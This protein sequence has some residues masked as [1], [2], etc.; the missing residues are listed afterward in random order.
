[1]IPRQFMLATGILL[2]LT[3][4]MSLY[5]WQLRRH[6]LLKPNPPQAAQHVTVPT[7]GP[8][9]KVTVYVAYDNPGELHAQS[10]TVPLTSGRQQR[11]EELLRGL[12][13]IYVARNS[14]HPLA[15]GAE[16]HN[17][18]LVNPGMAVIDVNSDFLDGQ[19]S[20]I[21]A[22]ELTIASMI[23]TLSANIPGLMRVKILANGKE[24][25]TLAGHADL[26][27]FYDVAQIADLARQLSAQ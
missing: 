22:E 10:I 12:L 2:A 21:L 18:Y 6:E 5:L 7:A 15:P 14:P 24:R 13:N 23:Q 9:E 19:T 27:E 17:V 8:T 11:A 26:S 16:I 4:S 1:M 3:I 20:G 25:E